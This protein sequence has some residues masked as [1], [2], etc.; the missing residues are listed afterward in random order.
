VVSFPYGRRKVIRFD[1]F[2]TENFKEFWRKRVDETHENPLIISGLGFDPRSMQSAKVLYEEGITAGIVPINFSVPSAGNV[3]QALNEAMENNI[4]LLKD[5][6][7]IVEP[8]KI[9]MFDPQNRPIGGR[10]IVLELYNF[11]KLFNGATDI[12]IDIG[13]L[14]RV[15]FAPIISYLVQEQSSLNF[16]NLHVASLPEESIDRGISSDQVLEPNFLYGFDQPSPDDRFVWVP[17]V[18]KNDPDRLR[19]IHNKIENNCIEICPILPFRSKNPRKIDDLLLAL[20]DLLFEE[21]RTYNNNIIYSGHISPFVVYREIIELSEYYNNL[22]AD[23][24]YNVKV[25]ITPMDDKTSSVGAIIAA[26]EKKLPIMYADTVSYVVENPEIV[27]R[28]LDSEPMEIWVSGE[29]Y[30]Q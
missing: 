4:A 20:Q 14:P 30:E 12:I 23:L 8:I 3:D 6:N 13:G 5:Y 1:G 9:D 22:L 17:I 18:G 26:I 19:N 16:S 11:K 29:P 25:L 10:K 7:Q 21:I 2:Y 28:T 24:P 15:L 27:L